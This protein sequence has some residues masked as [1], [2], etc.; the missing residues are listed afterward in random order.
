M[1]VRLAYIDSIRSFRG[2]VFAWELFRKIEITEAHSPEVRRQ[3]YLVGAAI[4]QNFTIWNAQSWRSVVPKQSQESVRCCRWLIGEH[5]DRL[6][7]AAERAERLLCEVAIINRLHSCGGICL[8]PGDPRTPC[9]G[10]SKPLIRVNLP[11]LPFISCARRL[12]IVR[13]ISW[14]GPRFSAKSSRHL[15]RRLCER[16]WLGFV[17]FANAVSGII[18][19]RLLT[20][21]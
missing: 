1:G 11:A 4:H 19:Q 12:S 18:K 2:A 21:T 10:S 5:Q 9:I 8:L 14:T 16:T 20:P 3:A 13:G 6:A 15:H 7:E 17:F